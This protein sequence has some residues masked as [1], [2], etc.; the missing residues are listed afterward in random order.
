[1]NLYPT[2]ENIIE[3]EGFVSNQNKTTISL[4]HSFRFSS[5]EFEEGVSGALYKSYNNTIWEE[6]DTEV[7]LKY[8]QIQNNEALLKFVL[9]D[10]PNILTGRILT[11]DPK[12]L[13]VEVS[14]GKD[15]IPALIQLGNRQF[16]IVVPENELFDNDISFNIKGFHHTTYKRSW[17]Q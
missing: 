10:Q 7:V 11:L 6:G 8:V 16:V 2:Y 17:L 9:K 12:D 4:S 1:M 14:K 13:K 3:G 5:Q 15:K